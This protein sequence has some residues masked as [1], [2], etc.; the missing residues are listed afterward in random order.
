MYCKSLSRAKRAS[1]TRPTSVWGL[2]LC[3][4]SRSR[5]FVWLL[6]RTWIGK[7]TDCFA[8]YRFQKN[9]NVRFISGNFSS[10]TFSWKGKTIQYGLYILINKHLQYRCVEFIVLKHTLPI[11]AKTI[12]N[13]SLEFR[14]K[15]FCLRSSQMIMKKI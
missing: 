11:F 13:F 15:T 4:Q 3:F 9:K 2:A 1:L 5:P 12:I 10:E 8:V 6:T 14:I 7:N